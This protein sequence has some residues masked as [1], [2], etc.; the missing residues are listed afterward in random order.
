MKDKKVI[1]KLFYAEWCGHCQN[2][3]PEW[4]KLKELLEKNGMEWN[5]YEHEKDSDVIKKEGVVGF[6]TIMIVTEENG[7]IKKTEYK[8][9][10][11]ADA[12]MK[13]I[14]GDVDGSADSKY[15]QCGGYH[16]YCD[17]DN[18]QCGGHRD[19]FDDANYEVKYMKYK[20]KYMKAKAEREE[21]DMM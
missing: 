9:E 19:D 15:K 4:K 11:T 6:P 13:Y 2:F 16:K 12:I 14:M 17:V 8:G 7:D 5:E 21:R 18:K 1:V 10:R 3:K 20:A